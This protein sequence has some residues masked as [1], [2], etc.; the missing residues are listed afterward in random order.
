MGFSDFLKKVLKTFL[1]LQITPGTPIGGT[2]GAANTVAKV[3]N[4]TIDKVTTALKEENIINDDEVVI[5]DIKKLDDGSLPDPSGFLPLGNIR[6]TIRDAEN[7]VTINGATITIAG[8][9]TKSVGVGGYLITEIP[10]LYLEITAEMDGYI[11][12][13]HIVNTGV[14]NAHDFYLVKGENTTTPTEGDDDFIGPVQYTPEEKDRFNLLKQSLEAVGRLEFDLAIDLF[15]EA[16]RLE[17]IGSDEA[18]E[19]MMNTIVLAMPEAKVTKLK[20]IVKP[21]FLSKI[22]NFFS[23]AWVKTAAA[24]TAAKAA[25]AATAGGVLTV[26]FSNAAGEITTKSVAKTVTG[27]GTALAGIDVLATWLASDNVITGA[28]FSI[29]NLKTAVKEGVMTKEEALTHVIKVEGWVNAAVEFVDKSV[30]L[31]P[32]LIVF[33]TPFL[34]NNE[35]GLHDIAIEKRILEG[36]KE[37]TNEIPNQRKTIKQI[38]LLLENKK[39]EKKIALKNF[40]TKR[41][42]EDIEIIKAKGKLDLTKEEKIKRLEEDLE[43]L[44]QKKQ[45]DLEINTLENNLFNEKNELKDLKGG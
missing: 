17:S 42:E 44:N 29:R 4:V 23:L 6:G 27:T 14:A 26:V 34:I 10:Q 16:T 9:S 21:T 30:K 7:N 38:E 20:G 28:G 18:D 19:L 32:T 13:T 36:L 31:N 11:S 1:L 43:H 24:V 8:K 25:A 2:I 37:E 12:Q 35:K 33:K 22:T 41:L 15:N 40:K 3:L 45:F 5:K 39:D